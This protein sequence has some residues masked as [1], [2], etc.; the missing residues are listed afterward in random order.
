MDVALERAGLKVACE[1]SVTTR[2][3]HEVENLTKCLAAGFDYAV[4]V[5]SEERTL[6]SAR[7]LFAGADQE[8]IRFLI[9]ES[10][11]AFLDGLAKPSELPEETREVETP[12]AHGTADGRPG[13]LSAWPEAKKRLLIAKDAAFYIG[14]APQ[15]LAKMRVTG[16]S[17]PFYKVGRQVLYDRA[18]LDAWLA[19]RRRRSTSDAGGKR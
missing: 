10:L 1:I 17:P 12:V 15:T 18:D 16:D 9:P 7:G 11:V 8:R 2:V 14:L 4:F 13:G 5:C 19:D 3:E 6:R